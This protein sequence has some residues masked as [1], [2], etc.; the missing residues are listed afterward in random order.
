MNFI[1][2]YNTR[3]KE[4]ITSLTKEK[5]RLKREQLLK[6]INQKDINS[7]IIKE[8]QQII[9]KKGIIYNLK[10]IIPKILEED[11]IFS[12]FFYSK[13]SI[14]PSHRN[15]MVLNYLRSHGIQLQTTSTPIKPTK[16]SLP[17]LAKLNGVDVYYYLIDNNKTWK[18]NE[19]IQRI[20]IL[21][22]GLE[23]T[24]SIVILDDVISGGKMEENFP[25]VF[26]LNNITNIKNFI[27][28]QNSFHNN[29]CFK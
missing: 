4:L 29:L 16:Y 21:K 22:R 24:K 27:N 19:V 10:D 17:Y 23:Y 18:H 20:N 13:P 3:S 12:T 5:I 14:T 6:A 9:N 25:E 2:Y 26:E 15:S 8:I 11:N 7:P 28:E 1:E